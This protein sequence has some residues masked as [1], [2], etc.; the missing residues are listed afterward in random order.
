MGTLERVLVASFSGND[1]TRH[2]H[3]FTIGPRDGPPGLAINATEAY[4][5]LED[6]N[7]QMLYLQALEARHRWSEHGQ[8][9][10]AAGFAQSFTR[11][12]AIFLYYPVYT[13]KWP[14]TT[15]RYIR[16]LLVFT[17]FAIDDYT[18]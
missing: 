3:R 2:L 9:A 4:L 5:S 16:V 10:P 11:S 15:D 6:A 13:I 17:C 8:A 18:I 1:Y 7:Q 14:G 12:L